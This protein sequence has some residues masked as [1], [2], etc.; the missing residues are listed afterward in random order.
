MFTDV[1]GYSLISSR[2]EKKA[3]EQVAD[4]RKLLQ[5]VFS[6]YD[7][8]VVKTM[9][10]GF[11]VEF[12]SAVKAVDCAVE[13]QSE[14]ARSN[15]DRA[16]DDRLRIRIGVHVGDVVH[17][18]GDVMGDAV[19]I[20]SRVQALADPGGVLVTRQVYDQVKGKVQSEMATIGPRELKNIPGRVEIFRVLPKPLV[21][22]EGGNHELDPHRVA[23]LPFAN[24][25]PDPNDGYFADGLT[26][27]LISTISQIGELSVISRA[28]AM[29]YKDTR[30]T[31]DQV[32]QELRVGTILEGSV[33]KA[34]NRVRI[35]AQLLN[36]ETDRY[37][38]SQ[39]YDRD[40]TD[41]FGVQGEIAERVAEGL[42]VELLVREKQRLGKRST[43]NTEAYTFYLQGR[44]HWGERSR[45]GSEK[46]IRCFEEA[47]RLDPG[48]S[49]AYSGLADTYAVLADYGWM[50]STRAGT[51]ARE[52][53]TRAL[54]LD[55]SLAEAHASLGLVTVNHLWDFE[56][57]A[58]L[59]RVPSWGSSGRPLG[60]STWVPRMSRATKP[61]GAQPTRCAM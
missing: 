14:L 57:G 33:R 4:L 35:A 10:D 52:N 24:L 54:A 20:A 59:S 19:N 44:V 2:N 22:E 3:L 31:K 27:E 53:A 60:C 49:E 42:K 43:T 45:E 26:E 5:G 48:F 21:S 56:A 46:A 16:V 9:G 41:I 13:A 15:L 55:E 38:W 51:L 29:R 50:D 30:L 25:S 7:G 47:I 61:C 11:L 23:I 1:V 28:S 12:A 37:V 8:R 40:L 39:N 32:G 34:G 6:R 36:V 58:K 17:S 18:E